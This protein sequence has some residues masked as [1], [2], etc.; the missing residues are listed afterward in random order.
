MRDSLTSGEL[1]REAGVNVQ[2]LRYYERRKL[3]P[4]PERSPS[5]YRQYTKEDLRRVR[6]IKRAQELGFSL[7]EIRDL[8]SLRV[9]GAEACDEVREKT[10]AKMWE[11]DR[12]MMDLRRVK[13]TLSRLVEACHEGRDTGACPILDALSEDG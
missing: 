7:E 12:K 6:F 1:A 9:E 8:L 4:A 2:T 11:V 3:L 13:K 5:G 10:E